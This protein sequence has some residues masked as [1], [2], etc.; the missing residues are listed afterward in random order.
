MMDSNMFDDFGT[1]YNFG[2]FGPT[3]LNSMVLLQIASPVHS[4]I[5]SHCQTA[6]DYLC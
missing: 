5:L 1:R 2:T 3:P 4:T 6:V